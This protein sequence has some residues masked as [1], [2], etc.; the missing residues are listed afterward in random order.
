VPTVAGNVV[1]AKA[2]TDMVTSASA[3]ATGRPPTLPNAV[4]GAPTT[5]NKP[6]LVARSTTAGSP[7]RDTVASRK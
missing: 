7:D 2:G 6:R 1:I 4:G 5:A 3:I